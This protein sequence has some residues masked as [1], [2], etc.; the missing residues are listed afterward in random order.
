[1][2]M[3]NTKRTR[4]GMSVPAVLLILLALAGIAFG[5]WLVL[6]KTTGQDTENGRHY[7]FT[8]QVG[9]QKTLEAEFDHPFSCMSSDFSVLDV[10]DKT[11]LLTAK[12][13]G[14]ATLVAKDSVSGERAFFFVTVEENPANPGAVVTDATTT[15]VTTTTE[16]TTT[17]TTTAAPGVVSGIALSYYSAN[18]KV[19]EV[20]PY[21]LV[22]MTPE[23]A[24]DKS[25]I[26]ETDNDKVATVDKAGRITGVGAG[27][28]KI[29]VT[30]AA[31]PYIFAEIDVTVVDPNAPAATTS[32]TT[33]TATDST[34][35]T[36]AAGTTTVTSTTATNAAGRPDQS[37]PENTGNAGTPSIE[38]KNGLTYVNGILI[39]NK[40]YAL[41]A[42][43]NPGVDPEAQA[44]FNEMQAAA[45]KDG[46]SLNICSGFRSY[47]LQQTLYNNY[48]QR[49][50]KAAADR[51]SARPGHSEHQTGLAFDI[52]KAS[53]SFTN[54]PEA[55]W[56]AANCWKYGFILRYPEGKEDITGY[57]Y[58][59]WHVRYLGKELAKSVYDSGLTL[60]EYLGITSKYAE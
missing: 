3:K 8:M 36:D 7:E 9:E 49:D 45:A 51:Y 58:E 44:A 18:V 41:P 47:T 5:V 21:A 40:T 4:R 50:G 22:T 1:M 34:A 56:V 15:E 48:V 29:R 59:S 17:T 46:L 30:A 42:T 37:V 10:E 20:H 19:G 31:N 57:M 25:E 11:N 27:K 55:K 28:C 43:Y 33:A 13:A 12:K 35:A 2:A 52:N 39:A 60:E 53:S 6:Q 14:T 32:E 24:T 26:W 38:V 23:D 54:T 16:E